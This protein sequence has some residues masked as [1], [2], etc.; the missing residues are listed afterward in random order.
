MVNTL[1]EVTSSCNSRVHAF[2]T[3]IG[4]I[5]NKNVT[6]DFLR[7]YL[8]N[9]NEFSDLFYDKDDKYHMERVYGYIRKELLENYIGNK[10]YSTKKCMKMFTA[11]LLEKYISPKIKFT[12]DEIK[13]YLGVFSD[14]GE[15]VQYKLDINGF[16][17][18]DN[19]TT[20]N[21][22]KMV[23]DNRATSSR[24]NLIIKVDKGNN[25]MPYGD[26]LYRK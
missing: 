18:L 23:I 11:A 10:Y 17:H 19:M 25:E 21:L 5:Y 1:L 7:F 16:I 26:M 6:P 2:V 14:F 20:E 24:G 3:N 9:L 13:N 8:S 4:I 15:D 12:E 22:L